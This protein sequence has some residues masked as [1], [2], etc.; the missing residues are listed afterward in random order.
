[1]QTFDGED[2]VE[3]MK[4]HAL[5]AEKEDMAEQVERL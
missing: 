5:A 4:F 1:V 2:A 3:E